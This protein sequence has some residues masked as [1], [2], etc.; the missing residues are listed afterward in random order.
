M[1]KISKRW[2]PAESNDTGFITCYTTG[3]KGTTGFLLLPERA[4]NVLRL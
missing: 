1:Y 4:V 2:N 3:Y